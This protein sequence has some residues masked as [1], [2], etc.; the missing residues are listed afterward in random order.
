MRVTGSMTMPLAHPALL[1]GAVWAP[2][3]IGNN[4]TAARYTATR[5]DHAKGEDELGTRSGKYDQCGPG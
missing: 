3:R 5:R 4:L 2:A 1:T